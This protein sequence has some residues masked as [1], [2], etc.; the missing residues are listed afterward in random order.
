MAAS[1]PPPALD[2]LA[3]FIV[4]T[5][6]DHLF[7]GCLFGQ[8]TIENEIH[9][10]VRI[11]RFLQDLPSAVDGVLLLLI[12]GA[13]QLA[14][15]GFNAPLYAVIALAT[16]VL[17]VRLRLDRPGPASWVKS[18][19]SSR[20]FVFFGKRSYSL[21]LWHWLIQDLLTR[22]GLHGVVKIGLYVALT[23]FL[24]EISYSLIE[25]PFLR[26]KN[27]LP[28]GLYPVR[29]LRYSRPK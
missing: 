29:E 12:L 25:R 23:F 2:T 3:R 6:V 7:V 9:Q 17:T 1:P 28:I 13:A 14:A 24:A 27:R 15:A 21:Y 8:W 26:L 22:L 20:V 11:I 18:L 4:F 10:P 19:L 5:R 16:G